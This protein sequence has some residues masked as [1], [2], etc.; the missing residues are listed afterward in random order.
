[1]WEYTKILDILGS[2][3]RG[4][5][6]LDAGYF[7]LSSVCLPYRHPPLPIL[8]FTLPVRRNPRCTP[9]FRRSNMKDYRLGDSCWCTRA[10]YT[11]TT[12]SLPVICMHVILPLTPTPTPIRAASPSYRPPCPL[13]AT[14]WQANESHTYFCSSP[15]F[16]TAP[17]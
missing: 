4:C 15:F 1:M 12:R 17:R 7:F 16:P 14:P 5:D 11:T 3:F 10:S 8:P 2:P 9:R 6:T 13:L